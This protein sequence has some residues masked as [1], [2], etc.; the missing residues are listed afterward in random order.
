MH[1]TPVC[2][3]TFGLDL[4]ISSVDNIKIIYSSYKFSSSYEYYDI[5]SLERTQNIQV[6]THKNYQ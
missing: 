5:Q 3:C 1:K 6:T 4:P 2:V